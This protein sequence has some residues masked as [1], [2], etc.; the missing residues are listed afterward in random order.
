MKSQFKTYLQ[1]LADD[2]NLIVY[3]NESVEQYKSIFDKFR[4][5]SIIEVNEITLQSISSVLLDN[6]T[7]V[8]LIFDNQND[9]QMLKLLS[10]IKIFNKSIDILFIA[11]DVKNSMREALNHTDSILFEPIELD[12]LSKGFFD[13]LSTIYTLKNIV[14]TEKSLS[15][16]SKPINVD[17]FDEFLDTWEGKIMFLSQDIDE[18]VSRFDSGEL[19]N[20]LIVLCIDKINEVEEIFRSTSYTKRVAPVFNKLSGYLSTLKIENINIKNVEGFEYL[21]RIMEDVNVYIVEY[22]VD[23]IFKDVYVFQDSLL[24]NINFM[25][26]KL[27]GFMDDNS[28]LHFF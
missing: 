22:F 27:V 21:S 2:K 18:I 28:E 23:R 26:N 11:K 1:F 7:D 9:E 3:T 20:D 25:E 24:S 5:Y 10:G 6:K 14:N 16:V 15:K 4:T 13:I 19:S 17:E 12:D 8:V